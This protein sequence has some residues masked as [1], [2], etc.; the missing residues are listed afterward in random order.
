M[1][2]MIVRVFFVC[3]LPNYHCL[4]PISY[5][6]LVKQVHL[7]PKYLFILPHNQPQRERGVGNT[8]KYTDT[9]HIGRKYREIHEGNRKT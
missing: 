4:I 5:C 8:G 3:W 2:R 1:M 6:Y 9:K 7:S